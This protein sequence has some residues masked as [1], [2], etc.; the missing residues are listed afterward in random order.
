MTEFSE[1]KILEAVHVQKRIQELEEKQLYLEEMKFQVIETFD[2]KLRPIIHE[3]KTLIYTHPLDLLKLIEKYSKSE[4][5]RIKTK[6][7]YT[8][9]DREFAEIL[10]NKI[11]GKGCEGI[12][13]FEFE[14]YGYGSEYDTLELKRNFHFKKVVFNGAVA[15]TPEER[16]VLQKYEMA[17]IY[18]GY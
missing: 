5:S 18:C 11:F 3:K 17:I 4:G 1:A 15:L 16:K 14:S 2:E 13:P 6:I 12:E 10:S 8:G 7:A 9:I